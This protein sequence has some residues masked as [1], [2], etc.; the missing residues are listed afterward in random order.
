MGRL[1]GVAAS[2]QPRAN[3]RSAFSAFELVVIRE[4]R[5]AAFA[6][7]APFAANRIRVVRVFRG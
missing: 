4:I 2:R 6:V 3:F 1:P 5:V 7:V